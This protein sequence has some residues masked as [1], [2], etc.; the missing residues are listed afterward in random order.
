MT[1]ILIAT[2]ALLVGLIGGFLAARV[3]AAPRHADDAERLAQAR[4]LAEEYAADLAELRQSAAAD[5][6]AAKQDAAGALA[7]AKD[8]ATVELLS[9][10]DAAAQAVTEA[11]AAEAA[12]AAT[13]ERLGLE[14]AELKEQAKRDHDVIRAMEPLRVKL[15]Q[16]QEHVAQLERERTQQYSALTEQMRHAALT[17]ERLR[18]QT[19][20]LVGALRTTSARGQWGE[21]ELRRVLEVSG[22]SAFVDFV[23][24]S[25]IES[26]PGEETGRRP[27]VVVQLP[28]GKF[29]AIDAKVPLAAYLDAAAI[30]EQGTEA[31]RQ[32]KDRLLAQHSKALRGHV[33]TL[34][35]RQYWSGLPVSPEFTV[36][37]IPTESLLGEALRADPSLMEHAL[38]KNI[39]PATPSSLLALLKTVAMIWQQWTVADEARELFEL[40][41][42]LFARLGTF[43]DRIGKLGRTLSTAVR[44]YNSV[45]GSIERGVLVTARRFDAFDTS[46]LTMPAISEDRAQVR[47]L[48]APEFA[49]PLLPGDG[50]E[51][52]GTGEDDTKDPEVVPES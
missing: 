49:T 22:L 40:G 20:A 13:A 5:L 50:D 34:A 30:P 25:S 32:E 19:E 2:L 37:F 31:E 23:E 48:A 10:K 1:E 35:G 4:Q 18:T 41:R 39:A 45:V 52:E 42:E 14:N 11:R 29:I 17:D 8:A 51:G 3:R 6:A 26:I 9:A 21:M 28:G 27:D 46:K 43:G 38:A 24:Q 44:D 16:V 47:Q 7:Q 12:A 15:A 33:D 36:M